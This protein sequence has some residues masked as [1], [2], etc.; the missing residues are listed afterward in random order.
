MIKRF[1]ASLM[2]CFCIVVIAF[3]IWRGHVLSAS[4]GSRAKTISESQSSFLNNEWARQIDGESPWNGTVMG[5]RLLCP[6]TYQT[7]VM[8]NEDEV[9]FIAFASTSLNTNEQVKVAMYNLRSH[10]Y[11]FCKFV[12]FIQ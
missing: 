7:K 12:H 4:I 8:R 1:Y 9:V 6:G 10:K 2:T 3:V 11:D 5:Q